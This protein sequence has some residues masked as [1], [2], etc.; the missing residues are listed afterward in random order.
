MKL[1][2]NT[3]I[4]VSLV[5]VLLG[6]GSWL[7]SVYAE[8]RTNSRDIADLKEQIIVELR[9]INE[10]LDLILNEKGR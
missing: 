2:E 8:V 1:T 10:R 9:R 4:P 3:L 7:T 6:G 5:M